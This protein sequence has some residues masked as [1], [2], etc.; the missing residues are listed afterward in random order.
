M[1]CYNKTSE[2]V[3][4]PSPSQL[5]K[6]VKDVRQER[7]E[8]KFKQREQE[9][10][11]HR[12]EKLTMAAEALP[13]SK[14]KLYEKK[15]ELAQVII[16]A[17]LWQSQEEVAKKMEQ[18]ESDNERARAISNQLRFRHEM[19]QQHCDSKDVFVISRKEGARRKTEPWN[20]LCDI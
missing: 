20:E 16:D 13:E 14:R 15:Q 10:S 11:K 7:K 1:Y 4:Q 6:L 2:W 9:I 3:A 12:V 17:R 8:T 18:C 19:L 5:T